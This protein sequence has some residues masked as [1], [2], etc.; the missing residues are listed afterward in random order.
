MSCQSKLRVL[1]ATN[2]V[3]YYKTHAFHFNVEGETFSQDHKF[4]NDLYDYLHDE[5][6]NLGEQLR[7]FNSAVLTKLSDIVDI[8]LVEEES[9]TSDPKVMYRK[10]ESD[11]ESL[12][13]IGDNLYKEA[14]KEGHASLETYI[15]DYL[16]GISKYLWM[17][18]ANLKRSIK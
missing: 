1:Y 16:V 15:G 14:G 13:A 9:L 11:L 7:Q 12:I 8:S 17:V 2:F 3:T 6:D 10:L 5:H 4:F 18:K